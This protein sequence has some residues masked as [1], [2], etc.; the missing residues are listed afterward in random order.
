M[1]VCVCVCMYT[2]VCVCVVPSTIPPPPPPVLPH[3]RAY[4]LT[5]LA[6]CPSSS[7]WD[8]V[9][10]VYGGAGAAV[11]A[12]VCRWGL[13]P[14]CPGVGRC[15]SGVYISLIILLPVPTA[16]APRPPRS[17]TPSSTAPPSV[18]ARSCAYPLTMLALC[19]LPVPTAKA[20]RP[21]RSSTPSSTVRASP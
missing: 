3:S 20:P 19:L 1:C 6:S 10:H 16:K 4:P 15:L 17:S 18:L 8:C 14:C 2:C 9:S 12:A 7:L 5:L 21:P 13:C 11:P